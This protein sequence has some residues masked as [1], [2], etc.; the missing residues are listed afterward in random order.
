MKISFPHS[1]FS[2]KSRP[3]HVIEPRSIKKEAKWL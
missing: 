1:F 2:Q 3:A